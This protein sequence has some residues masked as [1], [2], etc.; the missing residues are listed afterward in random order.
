MAYH[1]GNNAPLLAWLYLNNDGILFYCPSD[2][3]STLYVSHSNLT[4]TSYS[5]IY[6]APST[7][8]HMTTIKHP[9]NQVNYCEALS[10][11]NLVNGTSLNGAGQLHFC[12]SSG[13][14]TRPIIHGGTPGNTNHNLLFFDGHTLTR[15]TMQVLQHGRVLPAGYPADDWFSNR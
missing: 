1:Y 15:Q 9:A 10:G 6:F 4:L 3:R 12:Y 2:R 14:T 7:K 13:N 5:Q 8:L 11:Y